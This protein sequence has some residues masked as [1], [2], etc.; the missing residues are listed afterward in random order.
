MFSSVS[1]RQ[2]SFNPTSFKYDTVEPAP[3]SGT[4]DSFP[5]ERFGFLQ[6]QF[7][8]RAGHHMRAWGTR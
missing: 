5:W 7:R 2:V 6:S 8:R 1:F 4:S 3:F